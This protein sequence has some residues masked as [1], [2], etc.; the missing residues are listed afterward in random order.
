MFGLQ[1]YKDIILSIFAQNRQKAVFKGIFAPTAKV[2][3]YG[4]IGALLE[5]APMD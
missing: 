3:A 4:N 1:K 5:F 2:R